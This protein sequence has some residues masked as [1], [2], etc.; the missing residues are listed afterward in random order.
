MKNGEWHKFLWDMDE[1]DKITRKSEVY[2]Q[3]QAQLFATNLDWCD[4]YFCSLTDSFGQRVEVDYQWKIN[5]FKSIQDVFKYGCQ[6]KRNEDRFLHYF[7]YSPP[8]LNPYDLIWE[9]N[10]ESKNAKKVRRY[11]VYSIALHLSRW[12]R[13]LNKL[14]FK[15]QC[16]PRKV[17]DEEERKLWEAYVQRDFAAAKSRTCK[18]CILKYLIYLW[19]ENP[20]KTGIHHKELT[21]LTNRKWSIP[22]IMWDQVKKRMLSLTVDNCIRERSCTC[23]KF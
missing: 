16:Y 6:T 10:S 5:D 23:I 2:Q 19:D 22:D 8:N 9:L 12:V 20:K 13:N 14:E 15:R 1:N 21:M 11:F 4:L 18:T 3:I 7:S 17:T